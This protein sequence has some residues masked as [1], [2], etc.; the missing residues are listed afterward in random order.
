MMTS[1]FIPGLLRLCAQ[2]AR[3]GSLSALVIGLYW[4]A[5]FAAYHPQILDTSRRFGP[6]Q[7]TWGQ[8]IAPVLPLA[9]G[10][11]LVSGALVGVGVALLWSAF[12]LS[13]GQVRGCSWYTAFRDNHKHS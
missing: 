11:L 1:R 9:F 8:I 6:G 4:A 3:L 12:A 10:G 7:E 2:G 13:L 5:Q